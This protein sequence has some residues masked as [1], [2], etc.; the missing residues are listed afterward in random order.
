MRFSW[1][2]LLFAGYML[3]A[4]HLVMAH[5]SDRPNLLKKTAQVV[6]RSG[7]VLAGVF[8][9]VQGLILS[10]GLLTPPPE[11]A[12][13]LVPGAGI[14]RK[15]PSF[16]LARRLDQAAEFLQAHPDSRVILTGGLAEGQLASEAQVM[17]WYLE[18]LGI[19]NQ[20]MIKE[21]QASNTLE[22]IVYSQRLVEKR[23][24]EQLDQILIITSDYHLLRA[25]MLARR[26]GLTAYGVRAP[27]PPG[28]YQE[29]AI[30]EF[31]ALFK[32]MVFD[33]P[34]LSGN[35]D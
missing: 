30:R 16:T 14:I 17:A 13:V 35:P 11:T 18:G 26:A 6:L 9:I 21:E 31:F 4:T 33:W 5:K 3:T 28:L 2:I 34:Q 20:R 15:E 12:Y 29:Y 8:L 7:S 32:S 22:N 27:S 23:D 25:Q 10:A 24:H 19:D 1:M